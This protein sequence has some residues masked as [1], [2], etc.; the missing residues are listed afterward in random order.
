MNRV[1]INI[2][3]R[4]AGVFDTDSN[5]RKKYRTMDHSDCFGRIDV[6]LK[7]TDHPLLLLQH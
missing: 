5:F 3:L 7:L 4:G 6:C 2:Q 1:S